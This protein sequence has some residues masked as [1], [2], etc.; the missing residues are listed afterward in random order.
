MQ[1]TSLLRKG[2]AVGFI[3]LLGTNILPLVTCAPIDD[4]HLIDC[5]SI[6][7]NV[8]DDF[9]NWTINGTMGDNGWYISPLNFSCTYNHTVVAAVYYACTGVNGT[10]YTQ[11][12]TVYTE[13]EIN[14]YWWWVDYQGNVSGLHGPYVF[15]IDYT[16]P[17][18]TLTVIPLNLVKT[19]W[20]LN[21]TV[22]D[23]TSGV[24]G[25]EFL[26]DNHS[27]GNVTA[28]PY[29][30]TYKG[31]GKTAQARTCDFAGNSA[32]STI[33]TPCLVNLGSCIILQKIIL[34][35]NLFHN[36]LLNH[37]TKGWNQ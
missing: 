18:I 33:F 27:I 2:F 31:Y 5:S 32:N 29:I 3:I 20:L 10:L 1:T 37:Q 35:F 26:I 28:F 36:L 25:V 21:A 23:A 12:F 14:F 24:C 7:T 4:H 11:P 17:T 16:P 19:K 8:L 34:F 15:G 13:G 6:T 9:V 22:A 30:F